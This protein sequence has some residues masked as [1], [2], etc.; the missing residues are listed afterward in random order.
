MKKII[1][2]FL[3]FLTCIILIG[4]GKYGEKDVVRDLTKIEKQR[5]SFR[6]FGNDK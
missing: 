5:L 2:S 4:C 3:T 6:C 1:L